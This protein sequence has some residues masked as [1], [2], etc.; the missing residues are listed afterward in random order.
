MY[1][2]LLLS[3]RNPFVARA[4]AF[5][6]ITRWFGYHH[7]HLALLAV[8]SAAIAAFVFAFASVITS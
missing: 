1:M 8:D 3:L 4:I 6:L 2:R 7:N 5:I